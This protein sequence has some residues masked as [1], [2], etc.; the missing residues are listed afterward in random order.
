MHNSEYYF[1][2]EKSFMELGYNLYIIRTD[3]GTRQQFALKLTAEEIPFGKLE[4]IPVTALIPKDPEIFRNLIEELQNLG[5]LPSKDRAT[6]RHLEDLRQLLG[7]SG[8]LQ[9]NHTH[10]K[11]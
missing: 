1:R 5:F 11:H 6:E 8:N 3:L 10:G 4:P 2:I 9:V 7:L